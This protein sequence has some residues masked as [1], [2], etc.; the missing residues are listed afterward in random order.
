MVPFALT[1]FQGYRLPQGFN[2]R[3][4]VMAIGGCAV[5]TDLKKV[6]S[7]T[8]ASVVGSMSIPFSQNLRNR[9]PSSSAL[10]FNYGAAM[11]GLDDKDLE[12]IKAPRVDVGTGLL[13]LSSAP[14]VADER[15]GRPVVIQPLSGVEWVKSEGKS[16]KVEPLLKLWTAFSSGHKVKDV[17]PLIDL[18][19]NKHS[20]VLSYDAV[21][22]MLVCMAGKL[23]EMQFGALPLGFSF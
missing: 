21:A 22:M 5:M 18:M 10:N 19:L 17:K 2:N 9:V 20:A 8:L 7:P 6:E 13:E 23:N 14:A 15:P 12:G 3:K 11:N 1:L 4:I 16:E